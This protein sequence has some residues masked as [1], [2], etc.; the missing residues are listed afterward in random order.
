LFKLLWIGLKGALQRLELAYLFVFIG[1]RY[2]D[3]NGG[4][5]RAERKVGAHESTICE[6]RPVLQQALVITSFTAKKNP[7]VVDAT[8]DSS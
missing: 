3:L 5:C 1:E 8:D 7:K 6:A 2:W 4:P